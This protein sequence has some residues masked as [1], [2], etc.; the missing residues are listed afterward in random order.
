[1]A[2]LAAEILEEFAEAQ[3][4]GDAF[5]RNHLKA[6]YFRL[7][8]GDGLRQDFKS[9]RHAYHLR[10]MTRGLCR[11]CPKPRAGASYYCQKHL[12]RSH[13]SAR[14]SDREKRNRV[15]AALA[16][17][18][19]PHDAARMAGAP[20]AFVERVLRYR[21]RKSIATAR[22]LRT[23]SFHAGRLLAKGMR[24]ARPIRQRVCGACGALGHYRKTCPGRALRPLAKCG[25]AK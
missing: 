4:R 2:F 11:S 22:K 9:I 8:G 17:G 10:Q 3:Q 1:M 24:K 16:T 23:A 6:E 15:D 18:A 13:E 12:E 5:A 21:A 7:I 19:S 25:G 20:V 14:R